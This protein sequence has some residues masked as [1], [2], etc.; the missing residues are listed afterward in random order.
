MSYC[1][2]LCLVAAAIIGLA[3]ATAAQA[4]LPISAEAGVAF[5]FGIGG[6]YVNRA[7]AALDALLA[8][9]LR[10]VPAGTLIG[11]LGANLQ[12][13]IMVAES[14][15]LL[16]EGGCVPEFPVLVSGG[17]LL[18][19]ERGIARGAAARLLAGPAYYRA[20]DGGSRALGLQARADL[21]GEA[22]PHVAVVVSLRGDVLPRF[23]GERVAIG[24]VGLG[25]RIW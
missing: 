15:I 7:G 13:A 4:R 14:C 22:L 9:R 19:L 10:A 5:R 2:T 16:P 18:G 20:P 23:R 3:P 17:V 11:A 24:S 12:G 1:R 6:T 8:A 21:A 25:L